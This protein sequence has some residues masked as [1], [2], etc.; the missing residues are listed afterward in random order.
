M[1]NSNTWNYV[2][3]YKKELFE[4]E[5]HIKSIKLCLSRSSEDVPD[6]T[7]VKKNLQGV[8]KWKIEWNQNGA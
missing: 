2:T 4:I 8:K 7:S 3:V 1:L 5:Y 6:R